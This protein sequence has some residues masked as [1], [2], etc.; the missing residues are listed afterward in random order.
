MATYPAITPETLTLLE[1][2]S[3]SACVL[4]NE[5]FRLVWCNKAYE[6]MSFETLD[7][8]RG[9]RMHDYLPKEAAD[10]R[11]A[12]YI[13]ALNSD[14]MLRVIQ[15]GA[16]ERLICIMIP[17]DAEAFGFKGV[18]NILQQA[19]NSG[20]LRSDDYDIVLRT[21][22]MDSLGMLTTSELRVL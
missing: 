2:L 21:P 8:M 13:Q 14:R 20:T 10:E 7:E 3:S 12:C 18:V 6:R 9:N 11:E 5:E 17:I 1:Q 16:D 15:L 22:C 4:R 19:P